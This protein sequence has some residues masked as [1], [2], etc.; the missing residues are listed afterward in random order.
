MI[1][2]RFKNEDAERFEY[3]SVK[4]DALPRIGENVSVPR[5]E[6]PETINFFAER[7]GVPVFN[8]TEDYFDYLSTKAVGYDEFANV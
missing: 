7:Y 5:D 6:D 4:I 3:A 8:N 2:A 1:N